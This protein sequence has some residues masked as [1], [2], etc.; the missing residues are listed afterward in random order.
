MRGD[1]AV[2]SL[3]ERL[4]DLTAAEMDECRES[5]DAYESAWSA[6]RDTAPRPDEFVPT[7]RR[8][9]GLVLVQNLKVELEYRAR[10]NA[11]ID[12]FAFLGRY[13]EMTNDV[14]SRAEVLAW[15]SRLADTAPGPAISGFVL[16]AL[17]ERF[18]E[19]R[20]PLVR[21]RADLYREQG[22]HF[23]PSWS[24]RGWRSCTSF[25]AAA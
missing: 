23:R 22:G 12:P 15:G 4:V 16:P 20:T 10:H 9:S 14:E 13:P 2:P 25:R 8:L 1:S 24:L 18:P 7:S 19:L 11:P 3:V 21:R 5:T 17:V 6:A